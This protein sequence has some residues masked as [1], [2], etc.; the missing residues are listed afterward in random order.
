[1]SEQEEALKALT[2]PVRLGW[3]QD[4]GERSTLSASLQ[5]CADRRKT[6]A[7]FFFNTGRLS[8]G[9]GGVRA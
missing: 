8:R 2:I 1:M 5:F 3:N 7:N 6:L 9:R 4:I